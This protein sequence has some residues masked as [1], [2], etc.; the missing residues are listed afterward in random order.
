MKKKAK[1]RDKRARA[2]ATPP[3]FTQA[4]E[5]IKAIAEV[6]QE[7]KAGEIA[8]TTAKTRAYLLQ[9]AGGL[10]RNCEMERRLNEVEKQLNALENADKEIF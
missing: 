6:Y 9:V 4:Q 10:Y 2:R 8:E 1:A 7:L 5:V 3:D